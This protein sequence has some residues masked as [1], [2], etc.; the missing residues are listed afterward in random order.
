MG[1]DDVKKQRILKRAD[2]QSGKRLK[3]L[4]GFILLRLE[5]I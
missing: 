5:M 4:N 1:C 2:I 3:P